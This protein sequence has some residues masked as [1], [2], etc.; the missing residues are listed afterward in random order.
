MRAHLPHGD[1]PLPEGLPSAA[2]IPHRPDL[3]AVAVSLLSGVPVVHVYGHGDLRKPRCEILSIGM[4]HHIRVGYEHYCT[5]TL[6]SLREFRSRF[7]LPTRFSLPSQRSRTFR[8]DATFGRMYLEPSAPANTRRFS[9][10]PNSIEMRSSIRGPPRDLREP[11]GTR[12]PGLPGVRRGAGWAP[13]LAVSNF[14]VYGCSTDER[15][16][17]HHDPSSGGA[18]AP[19]HTVPGGPH[20]S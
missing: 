19:F 13:Y 16:T 2:A 1:G 14:K 12:S 10:C 9:I 3:S 20:R 8:N 5:H 17:F 4:N 6:R 11:G 15:R 18:H 7:I